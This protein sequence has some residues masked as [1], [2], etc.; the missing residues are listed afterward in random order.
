LCEISKKLFLDTEIISILKNVCFEIDE[1][2][3]FD[4]NAIG[5]NDNHT[6]ILVDVEPK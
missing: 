2:Y 4:F 6:H 3:C 5:N 1:R